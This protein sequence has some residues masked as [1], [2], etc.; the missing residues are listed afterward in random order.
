ML[1][2][3]GIVISG[4]LSCIRYVERET[5][6]AT[7]PPAT[8]KSPKIQAERKKRLEKTKNSAL[9]RQQYPSGRTGEVV[10]GPTKQQMER[11]HKAY[12]N[13]RRPSIM[14]FL[15]REL[16]ADVVGWET[17]RRKV[18]SGVGTEIEKGYEAHRRENSWS[19]EIKTDVK[20]TSVERLSPNEDWT[21]AFEEGLY[22]TFLN[23]GV[24]LVDR[25]L[26]IRKAAIEQPSGY[27]DAI[28]TQALKQNVDILIEVLI[29]RDPNSRFGY[30]FKAIGK[31]VKDSKII[32]LT[33]SLNWENEIPMRRKEVVA[34]DQGYQTKEYIAIPAVRDMAEYL[35]SDIMIELTQ[36]WKSE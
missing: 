28:E 18:I 15:N 6:S 23:A 5:P 25:D 1:L 10:L 22:N 17:Y 21:W 24:N 4:Q 16:S 27:A 7:V 33:T 14:I 36:K 20:K 29:L 11:F 32:F 13:A 12:E 2:T 35:A 26:A 31:S 30:E 19:T 34:T 8:K 9:I 3:G